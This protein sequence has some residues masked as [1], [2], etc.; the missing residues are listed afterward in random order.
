MV[1]LSFL[2]CTSLIEKHKAPF[3]QL[4][5]RSTA[6]KVFFIIIYISLEISPMNIHIT[7]M[8]VIL[9]GLEAFPNIWRQFP[10]KNWLL[11]EVLKSF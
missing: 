7:T 1:H 10:K 3:N 9:G 11:G 6:I 4:N 5:R 8:G 2:L